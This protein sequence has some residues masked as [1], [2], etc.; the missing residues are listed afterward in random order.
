ME[1]SAWNV[2][3]GATVQIANLEIIACLL[4]KLN[5]KFE[6]SSRLIFASKPASSVTSSSYHWALHQFLE[7]N[8]YSTVT[9][10]A[11]FLGLSISQPRKRA[12]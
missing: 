5:G 9:L 11:K 4:P 7:S 6:K 8:N 1:L 10:F 3:K 2:R 12:Q